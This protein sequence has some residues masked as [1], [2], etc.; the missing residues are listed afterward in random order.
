MNGKLAL[1]SHY[2]CCDVALHEYG[3]P[4]RDV[5]AG[6]ALSNADLCRLIATYVADVLPLYI[7]FPECTELRELRELSIIYRVALRAAGRRVTNIER[8]FE[9]PY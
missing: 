6:S 9:S 7:P 1:W 5:H 3:R 8:I 2:R 4:C